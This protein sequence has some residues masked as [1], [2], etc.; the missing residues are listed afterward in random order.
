MQEG[1]ILAIWILAIM[2]NTMLAT[3]AFAIVVQAYREK[4]KR[5]PLGFQ[6]VLFAFCNILWPGIFLFN[7]LHP[8]ILTKL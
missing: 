3:Y 8:S 7:W 4:H 6:L 5:V 1:D 2:A